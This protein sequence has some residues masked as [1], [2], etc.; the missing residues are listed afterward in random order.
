MGWLAGR[1]KVGFPSQRGY[2]MTKRLPTATQQLRVRG[3]LHTPI[4]L[5]KPA[6]MSNKPTS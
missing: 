1:Y 4:D 5:S 3:L 2:D 6:G